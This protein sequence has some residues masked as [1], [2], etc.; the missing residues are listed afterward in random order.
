[1]VICGDMHIDY[2]TENEVKIQ[3]DTMLLSYNLHSL[4]NFPTRTQKH[5]S[6]AIDNIF[7]NT[8]QFNNYVIT[9][10]FNGLSDHDAQLLTLNEMKPQKHLPFEKYYEHK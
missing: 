7:L 1:M 3:L 6:S 2:L 5:S 9:P 8:S 4:V 10:M